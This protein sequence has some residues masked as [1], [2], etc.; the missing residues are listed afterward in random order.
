M[1]IV[2]LPYNKKTV[3]VEIDNKNFAA[4]LEPEQFNC[5]TGLTEEKIVEKALDNPIDSPKLENLVKGKN[6]M[7]IISSDHTRPLPS[8]ITMPILLRRI[9]RANSDIDIKI[10]IAT[11]FH[12]ATTR[13][14]LIDKFGSEIVENE[15]IVVHD[16]RD[17]NK[18]VKI[19]SFS[20]GWDLEINKVAAETELL[21]AEG[22]I[23]SHFFA[24][25]SGGR[26]SILPGIS[27]AK[28]IMSNHC[29]EF[30]ASPYARTGNLRNNPVHEDMLRAAEKA[31]LAFILNVVT[32]KNRK[33]INAFAGD[34]KLAHERGCKFVK[35]L[36]EV[37]KVEA[38]I[39]ISTN[40]GYPLDQNIYQSVKG[41]VA[42][43]ATCRKGGVIIMVA[44]CN[45]G[46]GGQAFYDNLANV[47]TPE[48]YLKKVS[49][50]SRRDT[51]PD[52]WES[53]MLAR[54]LSEHTVILVTDMCDPEII[55]NI[56]MLHTYTVKEALNKAYDILGKDAKVTVIPDG[57][58]VIVG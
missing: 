5:E 31:K 30:I 51:T 1:P 45:D 18:L 47:K 12:R 27:S 16:S 15:N 21:I 2:K 20:S 28:T 43:E 26:K 14:E 6:N 33:I 48:E 39:V 10:L 11:G 13:Q 35:K 25:F 41:M 49:N 17:R 32:D 44:A 37:K 55:E 9:R 57:A 3:E 46:H 58:G 52:Q 19:A 29:A 54:I 38:D 50:V 34:C 56:H 36:S 7:V 53:Q 22:L 8:K 42:A 23:K 24:G 40:G 4:V